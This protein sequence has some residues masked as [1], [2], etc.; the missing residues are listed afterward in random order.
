MSIA[1][2]VSNQKSKP[3]NYLTHGRGFKSWALT[4][5]H[6]RIGLLY[7]MF[8]LTAFLLG[9]TF[10]VL[11]RAIRRMTRRRSFFTTTCSACTGQ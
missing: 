7:M 9:G 8:V 4:L 5:D 6:K 1:Q 10:A 2:D 3:D 11:L